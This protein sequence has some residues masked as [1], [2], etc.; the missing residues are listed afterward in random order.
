MANSIT[1]F[2]MFTGAAE[3]AIRF[4][5]GLFRNSTITHIDRYGPGESGPEGSVRTASFT[6]AGQPVMAIDSAVKHAFNFTP[7]TSF[8]V[9]CENEA[10]L[11]AAFGALS[12]GGQVLM[13]M[14]N[15]GFSR[16]FT[17][18]NDRFGV[19]WQLNLR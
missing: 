6:V 4:Y 5:T 1:P 7:S 17:W 12:A 13:P 16:K 3:E 9:D 11:D 19:S 15:Y 8:F 10:E 14:D 2:L 18:V